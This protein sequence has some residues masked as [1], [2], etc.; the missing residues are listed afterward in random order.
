MWSPWLQVNEMRSK[1]MEVNEGEPTQSGSGIC[2]YWSADAN[3]LGLR[4]TLMAPLFAG[5]Y[6]FS[7]AQMGN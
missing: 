7:L 3:P 5:F 2:W 4:I 6:R 1:L